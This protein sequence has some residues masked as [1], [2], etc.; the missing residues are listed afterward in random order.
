MFTTRDQPF[1]AHAQVI[2]RLIAACTPGDESWLRLAYYSLFQSA[3][4]AARRFSTDIFFKVLTTLPTVDGVHNIP[5]DFPDLTAIDKEHLRG[6]FSDDDDLVDRFPLLEGLLDSNDSSFRNN[7]APVLHELQGFFVVLLCEAKGNFDELETLRTQKTPPSADILAFAVERAQSVVADL[8]HFVWNSDFFTWYITVYQ[9]QAISGRYAELTKPKNS[10]PEPE[11]DILEAEPMADIRPTVNEDAD[12]DDENQDIEAE[13]G[14]IAP[15][16]QSSDDLRRS[17]HPLYGP[18]HKT[19]S[20]LRVVTSTLHHTLRFKR[21]KPGVPLKLDFQVITYPMSDKILK[22]WQETVAELAGDPETE[23]KILHLLRSKAD[24]NRKFAPFR[25]GGTL[26]FNGRAHCEAV[27]GCLHSLAKRQQDISWVGNQSL[28]LTHRARL[29]F[30]P[31]PA[32]H[33]R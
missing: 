22:P 27:L 31:R 11:Q 8:H 3:P 28:V 21:T 9:C 17:L 32:C 4:K 5:A 19:Y 20:W 29:T 2:A 1:E 30:G 10:V 16:F 7:P 6:L 26:Q 18:A 23:K 14:D 13:I 12:A 33:R 15:D 24:G 25:P